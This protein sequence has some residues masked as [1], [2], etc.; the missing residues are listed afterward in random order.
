MANW[1]N[2]VLIKGLYDYVG[3]IESI[4]GKR[5]FLIEQLEDD[6]CYIYQEQ[7]SRKRYKVPMHMSC[8]FKYLCS[9]EC[10]V[11][12][13]VDSWWYKNFEKPYVVRVVDEESED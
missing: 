6:N 5:F 3:E 11:N 8:D 7:E 12:V 1:K 10:V 13:N 9:A 4:K 2:V